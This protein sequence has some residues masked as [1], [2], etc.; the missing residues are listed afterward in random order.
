MKR[1]YFF[2]IIAAFALLLTACSRIEGDIAANLRPTVEFVNDNPDAEE[3][4][5]DYEIVNFQW[6]VAEPADSSF[7][8][9]PIVGETYEYELISYE[10]L[11]VLDTTVTVYFFPFPGD[12]VDWTAVEYVP[13]DAYSFDTNTH[14]FIGLTHTADFTWL[15]GQTYR[16]DCWVHYEPLFSFAPI[17]AWYG[18]DPDGFVEA[19]EYFD[20]PLYAGA[21]PDSNA[22]PAGDWIRTRNTFA[23]INLTTE[24]GQITPHAVWLR[25]IDNDAAYSPII[26]RI[27]NRSNQAPNTPEIQWAKGGWCSNSTQTNPY[28]G[29]EEAAYYPRSIVLRDQFSAEETTAR[30][31]GI[32]FYTQG[33]DPD[34][35]VLYKI[36]L[37]YAY[38]IYR[39]D[40][41]IVDD[42]FDPLLVEPDSATWADLFTEVPLDENNLVDWEDYTFAEGG[43]TGR[44]YISLQNLESGAYQLSVHVR[45]DGYEE[46]L[47]PAWVRF[48]VQAM[49]FDRDILVLN[50]TRF[51]AGPYDNVFTTAELDSFYYH[52]IS[53]NLST[54]GVDTADGNVAY[55]DISNG[56][57]REN[58]PHD[59]LKHYRK[60]MWFNDDYG[61][62]N[63]DQSEYNFM[64]GCIL[65][66]YM[67]MGGRVLMSGWRNQFN[68]WG[69]NN[70]VGVVPFL[71]SFNYTDGSLFQQY[72]GVSSI[73]MQ[74]QTLGPNPTT[75]I[76]ALIGAQV[77]F[78]DPMFG[79]LG[80]DDEKLQ[81]ILDANP[82]ARF[83]AYADE[84]SGETLLGLK[85]TEVMA[86]EDFATALYT[87]DS[88]TAH[89][90][91]TITVL[92]KPGDFAQITPGLYPEW[93][94]LPDSIGCWIWP[95]AILD[96]YKEITQVH[97]I[98]NLTRRNQGLPADTAEFR[99]IA[100]SDDRTKH[101][102]RVSHI[103]VG[104]DSTGA[105]YWQPTDTVQVHVS[106]APT[107][108]SHEKPVVAFY[109]DI[110]FG[111]GFGNI[112]VNFNS[113]YSGLPLFFMDNS[114]GD[115]DLL[116][117]LYYYLL[118]QEYNF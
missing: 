8:N 37:Q 82:P 98:I 101:M 66:E 105:S 45:D 87:F 70:I 4:Q 84:T 47:M 13:E 80:M 28:P 48:K 88:Y 35:Q 96:R 19:Y 76:D 50:Q 26:S 115:I 111:G 46:A 9:T 62:E 60:V 42:M 20:Q 25:A 103:N 40:E 90:P 43:W 41:T 114:E 33:T 86:L 3:V 106:Y 93:S 27:F 7:F 97:S 59:L 2:L 95:W 69:Q 55:L 107:L 77:E 61:L 24:L 5:G 64:T 53:E 118:S 39:I 116:M 23:M 34:D 68:T 85:E 110:Q 1:H 109:E 12:S 79:D 31:N 72:F 83:I 81:Q 11:A 58:V 92:Y 104:Y 32:T 44:T 51:D 108:Y 18:S 91:D 99:T 17:I 100:W 94:E 21:V 52:L 78:D 71:F 14:R 89:L 54:S 38:R 16:I 6:E 49:Q 74:A 113:I 15:L 10:N 75:P 22:I 36:P 63:G 29:F 112:S 117:Q 67:D 57:A 102:L 65:S 73:Y 56:A 30:W